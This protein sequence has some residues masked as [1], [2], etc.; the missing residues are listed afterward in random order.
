MEHPPGNSPGATQ[1]ALTSQAEPAAET[2]TRWSRIKRVGSAVGLLA[3]T[4][5]FIVDVNFFA[6]SVSIEMSRMLDPADPFSIAFEISNGGYFDVTDVNGVC[7]FNEVRVSETDSTIDQNSTSF[8]PQTELKAGRRITRLCHMD[9]FVRLAAPS[10]APQPTIVRI[11]L[12][13]CVKFRHLRWRQKE[14]QRRF[15]T[16]R[17][18]DGILTWVQMDFGD[19][20]CT[21]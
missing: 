21:P 14:E 3:V 9:E 7:I 8:P 20:D 11:D 13:V 17:G 18:K 10:W 2:Q 16:A 1:A 5:A 4:I 19:V 12:T 6:P 15:V